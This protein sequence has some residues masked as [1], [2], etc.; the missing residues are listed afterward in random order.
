MEGE[1]RKARN[2]VQKKRERA[3]DRRRR[4]FFQLWRREAKVDGDEN[5]VVVVVACIKQTYGKGEK[6]RWGK[7]IIDGELSL[8]NEWKR[9]R[10]KDWHGSDHE[11][12]KGCS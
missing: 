3:V 4:A 6:R 8:K 5:D 2:F 12:E 1:N 9:K 10:K 7:K 11:E